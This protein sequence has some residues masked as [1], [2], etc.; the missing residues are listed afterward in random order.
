MQAFGMRN[1]EVK[2]GQPMVA[3]EDPENIKGGCIF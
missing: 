2:E 3:G 1:G